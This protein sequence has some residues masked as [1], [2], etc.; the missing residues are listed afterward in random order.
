MEERAVLL[1]VDMQVDFCPGG[2]LAVPG[3]DDIIPVINRYIELCQRYRI[4]IFASRDWHPPVTTHFKTY[5][6][7]WPPHCIQGTEGARFHPL[8]RLPD[9]VTVFSKGMDPD[10][11]DYS[12][13]HA[14]CD[15]GYYLDDRLK[16]EGVRR[17]YLCGLATDYC[18]RQSSLDALR[19][20]Y[21]VTVFVDAVKG[22]DL[23]PGDSQRALQEISQAGAELMDLAEFEKRCLR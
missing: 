10:K 21:A 22:V 20:G 7:L 2:S 3:G 13:F 15:A 17:L 8:L 19:A 14:L 18:V 11:D 16:K 5:G 4:A 6:G 23:T 1:V 12:T 9:K